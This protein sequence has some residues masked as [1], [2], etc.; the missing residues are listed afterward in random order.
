MEM[1]INRKFVVGG[2]VPRGKQMI[3]RENKKHGYR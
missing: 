3:W 2:A 1:K